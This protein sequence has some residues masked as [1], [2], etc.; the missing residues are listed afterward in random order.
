[1][2]NIQFLLLESKPELNLSFPFGTSHFNRISKQSK[3]YHDIAT[4]VNSIPSWAIKYIGRK[5]TATYYKQFSIQEGESLCHELPWEGKTRHVVTNAAYGDYYEYVHELTIEVSQCGRI[6]NITAHHNVH[7]HTDSNWHDHS[8]D[9]FDVERPPTDTE[10]QQY[11][12]FLDTWTEF[13]PSIDSAQTL[14]D[15]F[16]IILNGTVITLNENLPPIIPTNRTTLVAASIPEKIDHLSVNIPEGITTVGPSIFKDCKQL[17][18]LS[19]P[20]TLTKIEENAFKGVELTHLIA[21]K[22]PSPIGRHSITSITIPQGTCVIV[23]DAFEN[24]TNLKEIIIPDSVVEIESPKSSYQSDEYGAFAGC[25]SLEKITLPQNLKTIAGYMFTGCTALKEIAIPN[26]V[27]TIERSAFEGCENLEKV[28]FSQNIKKIEENAFKQ[29][30]KLR[31]IILPESLQHIHSHTFENNV[32]IYFSS[33]PSQ[34]NGIDVPKT[35]LE[36]NI[37]D[38]IWKNHLI[39]FANLLKMLKQADTIIISE[40]VEDIFEEDFIEYLNLKR[41]VLPKSFYRFSFLN[42]VELYDDEFDDEPYDDEFDDKVQHAF[43]SLEEIVIHES[44]TTIHPWAFYELNTEI[45]I[46][47]N[48]TD[49]N[50][51]AFSDFKKVKLNSIPLR[52]NKVDILKTL[53]SAGL[54]EQLPTQRP[55]SLS[56]LLN[57]IQQSNEIFIYEG[58]TELDYNIQE[59]EGLKKI[60][61]P[62][63]LKTITARTFKNCSALKEIIIPDSVTEIGCGAFEECT[64][65][66]EIIIP[67][68]VTEINMGAFKG[69][70]NL[71]KVTLSTNLKTLEY[72]TFNGCSALKEIIIPNSVTEIEQNAFA[73]CTSLEKITLSQNLKTIKNDVF[74]GRSALKEI[75]IPN[76][77][78]EI[79]RDAFRGC[80]SLEKVTLSTNLKTLERGMFNGCSA[81]K[82]IIIPDSVTEIRWGAF[83]NCTNLKE[84][85]IP[86]SVTEIGRGAFEECTNLKEIIIPNSV[87][88]INWG[89]FKGCSNLEKVT[90]STNL[91]TLEGGT[92]NG[93]SA[94]KEIIIPDSVTT[95]G[96]DAFAGCS[97]LEKV[98]LSTNL[99]TLEDGTFNGC[100]ALK[101]IIIPDSV[102]EIRWGAF[103]GCTSLEKI[104]LPQN[105]KTI[106]GHMFTGGTALKEIIIPDCVT[107]I[108]EGAF[109]GCTS[110]EK[111]TLP[112]NLKTIRDDVFASC[113]AL[114][115]III[116]DSVTE[117]NKGTFGGCTSLEKITLPPILKTIKDDAFAGC[118][119]LKEI[120]IPDS[121]TKIGRGAFENCTNLKEII[122]PDSVVEIERPDWCNNSG[123]FKGC[124][125]LEKITL[126]KNMTSIPNAFQDCPNLKE[127]V[128]PEGTVEITWSEASPTS[129]EKIFL[130]KTLKEVSF[131]INQLGHYDCV[132]H[133]LTAVYI[134]NLAAWC[135]IKFTN[136]L[137]NPLH[138]AKKFYINDCLVSH[139]EIPETVTQINNYAFC[140]YKQLISVAI[141]DSVTKI[142]CGAF[143]YCTNLKEIIIPN[144]VTEIEQN[145]FAG[146][147]SLEKITLPQNLKTIEDALF[148]GCSALKEI[149]IPDNVTEIGERAFID[150]T[151]LEK[152]VL[153][154]NIEFIKQCAF[155]E[156]VNLKDFLIIPSAKAPNPIEKVLHI[157]Y[158]AFYGTAL[159]TL[160]IPNIGVVGT[161]AF[162]NCTALVSVTLIGRYGIYISKKAF[163]ECSQLISVTLLSTPRSFE[164]TLKK[165]FEDNNYENYKEIQRRRANSANDAFDGFYEPTYGDVTVLRSP[166]IYENSFDSC[167]NMNES[168]V[169]IIENFSTCSTLIPKPN[170]TSRDVPTTLLPYDL[171]LLKNP[172]YR[173]WFERDTR[174]NKR[175]NQNKSTNNYYQ[176][177]DYDDNSSYRESHE[178]WDW[179][180]REDLSDPDDPLHNL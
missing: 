25:S 15:K 133:N 99:K 91:K 114:K 17:T 63:S 112:Q 58:I 12:S 125:S 132:S 92:F 34:I 43:I 177:D 31:D 38:N 120:I 152:I 98:A 127:I 69:C 175:V 93:C 111:I 116:P 21:S 64:N 11:Q 103:K 79:E 26:S 53:K 108:N 121:V 129:L 77:V 96:R 76:S 142:G 157:G 75:I 165:L 24:C 1:M 44:T 162:R 62:K 89:A 46:P 128:V 159:Q 42:I 7:W 106:T 10:I 179:I 110:L 171:L 37:Y 170:V 160:Y 122:I 22:I 82:K 102:T 90:L 150:C 16:A 130:P 85:I 52:I 73:G 138:Y 84:I 94:L 137:A 166:I 39:P 141:P 81:L 172:Y 109:K 78:T 151:T 158:A 70:S 65:L 126:S 104:T 134:S 146:C 117:I 180:D 30:P 83:E 149:I 49:I 97:S 176:A 18:T 80:T 136:C 5:L 36:N 56:L 155:Y 33:L 48:V 28:V 13:E 140:G 74:V 88:E 105:L 66:K 100:S 178:V 20:T 51:N 72:G 107:E 148:A 164:A 156:C 168:L 35:L 131:E 59:I 54:Y 173:N 3:Q 32:S 163:Q 60:N 23:E 14:L 174:K 144:S 68:S 169:N 123:T 9:Q 139:L 87:T 61:L 45:N 115:E 4:L 55:I 71:E 86:D 2:E 118:S 113:S 67:N 19:L 145:A 40:G 119:S 41:I 50:L 147:T 6:I 154:T 27:T 8:E 167:P 101:E 29:C 47:R 57:L 143:E 124:T 135:D 161:E 153:T 95:I